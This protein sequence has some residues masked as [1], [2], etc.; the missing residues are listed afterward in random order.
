MH[1]VGRC[2]A[3]THTPLDRCG[4]SV[5]EAVGHR[6]SNEVASGVACAVA[7]H[8]EGVGPSPGGSLG[9]AAP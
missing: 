7:F 1:T 3:Q 6:S 5:F 8:G 9:G 4:V 2:S